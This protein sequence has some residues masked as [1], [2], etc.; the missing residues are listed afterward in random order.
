M[1]KNGRMKKVMQ[2]AVCF[3]LLMAISILFSGCRNLTLF[4]ANEEALTKSGVAYTDTTRR[5]KNL[6]VV[7]VTIDLAEVQ[8]EPDISEVSETAEEAD[9]DQDADP[10]ESTEYTETVEEEV[11]T[12]SAP[13]VSGETPSAPQASSPEPA[14]SSSV[15]TESTSPAVETSQP[16][17]GSAPSASTEA[18]QPAPV[19]SPSPSV[20]EEDSP[21]LEEAAP[22]APPVKP[23]PEPEPEPAGFTPQYSDYEYVGTL[24]LGGTSVQ[25]YRSYSQTVTDRDNSANY[26]Y[27]GF[28]SGAIIADHSYQAFSVLTSL[29]AGSSAYIEYADG[30]VRYMSCSNAFYGHNTGYELT[31][32][33]Y[34]TIPDGSFVMYTCVDGWENV[35]IA[36]WN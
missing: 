23:T 30:S 28:F 33:D 3:A 21:D 1:N 31:D 12:A 26:F 32:N 35:Y 10:A 25:L 19:Q 27:S 9:A 20:P 29:G 2:K 36:I 16:V 34:N 17:Q 11:Y 5:D 14:E 15:S 18:S 22:P 7:D 4:A 6:S 13:E 8:V 24:Y